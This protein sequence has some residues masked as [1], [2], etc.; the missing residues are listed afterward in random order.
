M[1]NDPFY[2]NDVP[3]ATFKSLKN[4]SKLAT[5]LSNP[6]YVSQETTYLVWPGRFNG[7]IY[8]ARAVPVLPRLPAMH[9]PTPV[10]SPPL[11]PQK[12]Q[13]GQQETGLLYDTTDDDVALL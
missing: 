10:P 5:L 6:P 12:W 9:P 8:R 3:P 2:V 1:S 11:L 7:A 4:V 13:K